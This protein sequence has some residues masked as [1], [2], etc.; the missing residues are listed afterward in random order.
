M[1][2]IVIKPIM[3]GRDYPTAGKVLYRLIQDKVGQTDKIVLDLTGVTMLP[4]MF[5][6]VSIGKF[7]EDYGMDRLKSILAFRNITR[8][9]A[10]RLREYLDRYNEPVLQA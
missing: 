7:I 10:N 6:N 3:D 1:Y 5:M 4:S 2:T 8:V 9:Q